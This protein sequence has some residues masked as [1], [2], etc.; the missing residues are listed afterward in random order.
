MNIPQNN[1]FK[2]FTLLVQYS[3]TTGLPTGVQKANVPEDKNYIAPVYDP[4]SCPKLAANT[5]SI[6]TII[7]PGLSA[8][9]EL[10][11]G[12]ATLTRSSSGDWV[13]PLRTYDSI[14]FNIY[15]TVDPLVCRITYGGGLTKQVAITPPQSVLVPGPFSNITKVEIIS[16]I[17]GN[18]NSDF[19]ND[20]S[21]NNFI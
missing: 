7:N 13:V 19:N 8:N 6:Q 17:A 21:N 18:F 16:N 9:A 20:T 11:F 5:M 2:I 12:M 10:F 1:G 14:K 4:I 3:S 15:N